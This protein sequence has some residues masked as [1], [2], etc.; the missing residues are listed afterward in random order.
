MAIRKIPNRAKI[1]EMLMVVI[2]NFNP[3]SDPKETLITAPSYLKAV[4]DLTDLYDLQKK[5]AVVAQQSIIYTT[6]MDYEGK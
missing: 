3:H 5:K 4:K 1:E 6:N 2:D